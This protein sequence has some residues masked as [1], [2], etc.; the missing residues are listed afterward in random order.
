MTPWQRFRVGNPSTRRGWVEPNCAPFDSVSHISHID[1]ALRIISDEEIRPSLV[2]DKSILNTERILVSWLS[3]NYWSPG[4]RYGNISFSFDFSSMIDGRHYYWVEDIAYNTPACRI[5][6]TDI[7]RDLPIFDPTAKDGPWWMD[8][9]T[10]QNYFNSGYC[11]E[12]MVEGT[13]PLSSL[14]RFGFVSHHDKYCSVYRD[15]PT[16][17]A[18]RGLTDGQGGA[19]LL[20]RAAVTGTDLTNVLATPDDR[21]RV[22]ASMRTA[23]SFLMLGIAGRDGNPAGSVDVDAVEGIALGRA[24]LSA[25]AFHR[26]DEARL[27][28]AQFQSYTDLERT[29]GAILTEVTGIKSWSTE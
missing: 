8:A 5:L 3:P 7:A 9:H 18:E 23:F 10:G 29:I 17:C 27:L 26:R 24:A 6:I 4:F 28:S 15:A 19:L 20:A 2:F 12:F 25:Y 13:V 11:L 1:P 22:L 16:S 21:A 14:R